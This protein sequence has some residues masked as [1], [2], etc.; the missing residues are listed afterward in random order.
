MSRIHIHTDLEPPLKALELIQSLLEALGQGTAWLENKNMLPIAC[1]KTKSSWKLN[2]SFQ[3]CKNKRINIS[4]KP[5]SHS[6]SLKV[7]QTPCDHFLSCEV[8]PHLSQA[9]LA[10]SA[11]GSWEPLWPRRR[12]CGLAPDRDPRPSAPRPGSS[13]SDPCAASSP[14][15]GERKAVS[16]QKNGDY[17]PSDCW[18]PFT[19]Q[20]SWKWVIMWR[21]NNPM[22]AGSHRPCTPVHWL[23]RPSG[24]WGWRCWVWTDAR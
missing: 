13:R 2:K 17:A 14:E 5:T 8:Q 3:N 15:A 6:H 7:D 4:N 1:R 22:S 12:R 20:L 11:C 16:C 19:T 18:S 21:R 9:C 23:R 10:L 24:C